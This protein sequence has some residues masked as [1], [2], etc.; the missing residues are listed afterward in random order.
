[1]LLLAWVPFALAGDLPALPARPTTVS[2]EC[3]Q[4]VGINLGS[5]ISPLLVGGDGLARCS[6]V[7]EPLSSYAHLLA[8]EQHA[9]HVRRLYEADTA[10]L[11]AERD[12]WRTEAQVPVTERPWF[13]AV[14]ASLLVS[15]AWLAYNQTTGAQP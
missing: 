3:H 9:L 5:P 6:S 2:G 14:T 11:I 10:A 13:V 15:G 4:S 8:M 12:Y 1:M 7:S